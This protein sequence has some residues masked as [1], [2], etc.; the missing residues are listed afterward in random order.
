M[1]RFGHVVKSPMAQQYEQA[2]CS[3]CGSKFA[4]IKPSTRDGGPADQYVRAH[5]ASMPDDLA[6]GAR[7]C[8]GAG[9]PPPT[10]EEVERALKFADNVR[11]ARLYDKKGGRVRGEAAAR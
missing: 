6:A 7:F 8:R 1:G 3:Y 5:K 2:H 11:R 9:S 10:E 4:L